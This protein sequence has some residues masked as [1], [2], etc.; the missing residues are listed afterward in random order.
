[1]RFFGDTNIDFIGKRKIAFTISAALI[2]LSVVFLVVNKGLNYSIDFTGGVSL[3]LDLTP[4][5][6]EAETIE[7]QQIRDLMVENG[8]ED[9]EIQ[10]I[11]SKSE[12]QDGRDIVLLKT[13]AKGK[14]CLLYTS[15]AADE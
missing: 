15:D 8:Y 5:T 3:E 4:N 9:I 12:G 13:K 14:N 11:S 10:T 7:I 1:M 6:D 2:L